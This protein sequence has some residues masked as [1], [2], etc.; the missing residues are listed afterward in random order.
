MYCK[1]CGNEIADDAT[2][3]P[4]CGSHIGD[5]KVRAGKMSTIIII[6]AICAILAVIG[7]IIAV[8]SVKKKNKEAMD[9]LSSSVEMNYD[10][11]AGFSIGKHLQDM[12]AEEEPYDAFVNNGFDCKLLAVNDI[13]GDDAFSERVKKLEI[14]SETFGEKYSDSVYIDK[15]AGY[16]IYY[17]ANSNELYVLLKD[18]LGKNKNDIQDGYYIIYPTFDK[19]LEN[20][21]N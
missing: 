5:L 1:K 6:V 18:K 14:P 8:S 4:S 17:N 11:N 15:A 19:T 2:F 16:F 13:T 21:L 9:S 20:Y 7:V 3:C 12:F 10:Y